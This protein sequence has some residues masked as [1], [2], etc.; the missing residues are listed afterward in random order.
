VNQVF[1]AGYLTAVMQLQQRYLAIQNKL[2][3][4]YDD[5]SAGDITDGLGTRKSQHWQ[6]E[7][8]E[9]RQSVHSAESER[10]GAFA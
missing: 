5:R 6:R 10:T 8:E 2:D 1:H 7:L 4:A 3:R 9:V